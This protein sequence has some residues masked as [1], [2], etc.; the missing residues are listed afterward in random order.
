M[1]LAEEQPAVSV[2]VKTKPCGL[3]G[4]VV[5]TPLKSN[6][7][8][9]LEASVPLVGTTSG[10]C[11][12]GQRSN[13]SGMPSQ[14]LAPTDATPSSSIARLKSPVSIHPVACTSTL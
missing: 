9:L 3:G 13:L 5:K 2:V 7:A 11:V 4:A 10:I 12:P 1:Y 8:E 14:S 6:N